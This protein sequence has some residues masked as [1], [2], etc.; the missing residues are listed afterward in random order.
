MSQHEINDRI[1]RLISTVIALAFLAALMVYVQR[2]DAADDRQ[3]RAQVTKQAKQDA[4]L[5]TWAKLDRKG[6]EMVAYDR[7][8]K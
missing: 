6:R 5:D 1:N 2:Q 8:K 4:Q 7:I 3:V